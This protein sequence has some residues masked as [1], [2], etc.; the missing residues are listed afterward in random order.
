MNQRLFA[1]LDL[2]PL[3]LEALAEVAKRLR[4][5]LPQHG[6]RW[7]RPEGIHLTLRFYGET[8]PEQVPDLQ[9]GLTRV[10]SGLSPIELGL[11]DLG[12]FPNAVAPR[13][14]WVGLTGALEALQTLNTRLETEAQ[15]LGFRPETRPF[16]PHLTLGRVN[17]LRAPEKQQLSQLLKET[18]VNAPGP[19]QLNQLSLINSDLKPM[20]AVYTRLGSALLSEAHPAAAH[21]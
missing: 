19:F 6:V 8:R 3:V 13:V 4:A 2:P 17:Q 11:S 15:A 14:I 18:V 9:A 10:V 1:A 21:L 12:V 5:Q 7:V 16:T 20:G